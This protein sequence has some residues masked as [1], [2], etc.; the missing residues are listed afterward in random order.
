MGRVAP[1]KKI[2]KRARK[3]NTKL[4]GLT[5][6]DKLTSYMPITKKLQVVKKGLPI[7]FDAKALLLLVLAAINYAFFCKKEYGYHNNILYTNH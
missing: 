7:S 2:N 3:D 6:K 4:K 1:N 5:N